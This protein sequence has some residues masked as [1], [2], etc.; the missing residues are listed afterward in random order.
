MSTTNTT[1]K[2]NRNYIDQMAQEFLE[3]LVKHHVALDVSVYANGVRYRARG[4]QEIYRDIGTYDPRDYFEYVA[5]K[6]IMSVS[7]E[8][9]L[10]DIINYH[11]SPHWLYDFFDNH[12]LY[13]E[14]GAA[15]N[16]SCYLVHDEEYDLWEY[17]DYTPEE[18][19]IE[20]IILGS[21]TLKSETQDAPELELLWKYWYNLSKQTGDVGSCVIGAELTFT[22]KNKD[23]IMLPASPYQGEGSWTPHVGIV[24]DYLRKLGAEQVRW[25]YGR[26]D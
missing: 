2:Y 5:H 8:G 15:W 6:H 20:P 26:L 9:P 21:N 24:V 4:G 13:Y 12:G 17:T 23:Y 22:Y 1:K 3:L 10:Y 7:F 18:E 16:F 19:K 25:D 14:L 11:V